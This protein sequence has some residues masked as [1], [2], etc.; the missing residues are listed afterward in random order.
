MKRSKKPFITAL[1]A[2][3][4]RFSSLIAVAVPSI[5][6]Q[7]RRPDRLI[8]VSD[9]RP[10]TT[11]E[12]SRLI[13]M[14]E[15]IETH[16]LCNRFASGAAGTWNTGLSWLTQSDHS[17][18]VAILD[19][20]DE[21]DPIH[22]ERCEAASIESHGADIVLSG[23][24]AKQAGKELPREPLRNVTREDFLCG[25][26]G[27]QGSNTFVTL[28]AFKRVG[29][30]T[31]GLSSTNDRDLAV[32][33]LSVEGL[34]ITF[35]NEM[36]ATWN[37]DAEPNSLSRRGSPEKRSGLQMFL[38]M[39]RH[40]MTDTILEKFHVRARSLFDIDLGSDRDDRATQ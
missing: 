2:T 33:L 28:S 5:L 19:D 18:Y 13:A 35:T 23:L 34:R 29:G 37:M 20:D 12:A 24:R 8:I 38:R 21:W 26:P 36:T 4:P 1:I 17:E 25:N 32:R 39:H 6:K 14:S 7:T 10:F 16:V 27:W 31:N 3:R 15:D 30:F 22:L 9:K 11:P 40:L